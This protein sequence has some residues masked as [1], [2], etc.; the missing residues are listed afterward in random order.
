MKDHGKIRAYVFEREEHICRCC[1]LRRADSMHE[2][3]SRGS[4]GKVSKRNSVAVC[5]DGVQGC[6]GFLQ[7]YAITFYR[8][9]DGAEGQLQFVPM[10]AVSADWMRVE[11]GQTVC[12][13]PGSRNS[14]LEAC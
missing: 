3:K 12:S 6:H 14:E 7:R 4:G 1:R 5:G 8:G 9:D 10:T 2:L 13:M 11:I